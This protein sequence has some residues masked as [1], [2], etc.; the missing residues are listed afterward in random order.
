[1]VGNAPAAV[2][3]A[4]RTSRSIAIS[5]EGGRS[6]SDHNIAHRQTSRQT[7][8]QTDSTH[9]NTRAAIQTPAHT[10]INTAD[11][12]SNWEPFEFESQCPR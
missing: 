3:S 6:A 9:P 12:V 8:R 7:D 1:M 11:M 2:E 4:G 5:A 10:A